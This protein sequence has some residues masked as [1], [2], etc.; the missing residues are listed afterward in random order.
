M[1]TAAPANARA[2]TRKHGFKP[3]VQGSCFG[4]VK[5][6]AAGQA[7]GSW[8]DIDA[9]VGG[10]LLLAERTLSFREQQQVL[11]WAIVLAAVDGD[12]SHLLLDILPACLKQ[13]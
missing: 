10:D 7:P 12:H 8:G 3:W 1:A 2:Q 5:C 9:A 11:Q 6:R 4:W 13:V